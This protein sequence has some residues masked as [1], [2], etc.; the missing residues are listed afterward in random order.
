MR[1][2]V[3]AAATLHAFTS[4]TDSYEFEEDGI[5]IGE[6][7]QRLSVKTPEFGNIVL[8]NDGGVSE[9]IHIYVNQSD[10]RALDGLDTQLRDK[11]E[12]L[13]LPVIAG[14]AGGKERESVIP[15][16]RRKEGK[17]SEADVERYEKHL[18]LKN[19]GVKGQKRIKAGRVLVVG[20]GTLGSAVIFYL[21]AAGV[22]EI[23]IADSDM[24]VLKN[25]QSQILYGKKDID[26]PKAYAARDVVRRQNRDL[27][28]HEINERI[29]A[30]NVERLISE[31]DVVV[32]ATDNYPTRYL[33]NDACVLQKKPYVYGAFYQ[34]EGVVTV[35]G[36]GEG[37]CLR[38]QYP[39]PPPEGLTP[40]CA[41][42]GVFSPLGGV[43]GSI[44]AAETLK[45]LMGKG[46]ILSGEMAVLDIWN[47]RQ[48]KVP[49]LKNDR[50]PLCGK[51]PSIFKVE[52]IDYQELCGI[53][54]EDE[55]TEIAKITP[56]ELAN[57]IERGETLTLIDVREPHE[58]AILRFPGAQVI[59]IGQLVRRQKE[60]NSD[61]D[62]I[63]ICK[64]GKRSILAINTLREA[65]YTG[66]MYSLKGGVD[67]AKNVI[68]AQEGAWL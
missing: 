55:V 42:N 65:G 21:A 52:E 12:V 11:D 54:R 20:A 14:G 5:R 2:E 22:G 37:P 4:W 29:T 3:I 10:I 8:T 7:I 58:R 19:I 35:Y 23:G 66:P 62:T 1:I 60:L 49:V 63:F 36:L 39:S 44:Q 6:L 56:Q 34:Y 33:L 64:E 41:E 47:N 28:V 40:T 27:V 50:C 15:E 31:Y 68:L 16:E 38:C 61:I 45:L 26:R 9:W 46:E 59:P 24:V 17:L 25:L 51:H 48:A 53:K 32:D 57:R 13:F 18:L 30:E 43:I 67:A